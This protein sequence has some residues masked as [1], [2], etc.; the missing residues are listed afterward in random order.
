MRFRTMRVS[1]NAVTNIYTIHLYLPPKIS[2]SA[3]DYEKKK[4]N[5]AKKKVE[6][7]RL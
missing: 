5:N 4:I 3:A 2:N 6:N 7:C 1:V